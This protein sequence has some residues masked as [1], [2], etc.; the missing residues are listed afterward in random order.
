MSDPQRHDIFEDSDGARVA[1]RQVFP[2]NALGITYVEFRSLADSNLRFWPLSDFME[3]FNWV[4]N[5]GST[6]MFTRAMTQQ[7]SDNSSNA[8]ESEI[9]KDDP[10]RDNSAAV[11]SN[12]IEG[13][14][15]KEAS[16]T[17]PTRA[18]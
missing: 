6:D 7:A 12:E 14:D 4:D 3:K 13:D 2:P 11:A 17:E 10:D 18:Q 5:F 9:L 15:S 8:S 1:V 16:G